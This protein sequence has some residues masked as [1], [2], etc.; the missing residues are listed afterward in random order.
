M[1]TKS[2]VIEFLKCSNDYKYFRNNYIFQDNNSEAL[3]FICWILLCKSNKTI[4]YLTKDSKRGEQLIKSIGRFLENLPKWIEPIFI[5]KNESSFKL[6]NGNRFCVVSS[7]QNKS[8][9]IRFDYIVVNSFS[10]FDE[11][12]DYLKLSMKKPINNFNRRIIYLI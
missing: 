2:R 6:E 8:N 12:K 11:Y 5:E 7:N 10:I 1:F 9:D 3:T 4:I